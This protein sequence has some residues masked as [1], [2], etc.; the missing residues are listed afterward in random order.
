MNK[1]SFAQ[2]VYVADYTHY[3]EKNSHNPAQYKGVVITTAPSSV[4]SC[5]EFQDENKI[6]FD[7]INL[8]QNP[9]LLKRHDGSLASQCECIF[10]AI[11]NDGGK[12]WMM[13]LE[14]KY[15]IPKN[16]ANN[17]TNALTQLKET[18]RFLKGKG[19]FLPAVGVKPYFVIS[20]PDCESIAPFDETFLDPDELLT[21]K[22]EF[23][24]AQVYHTNTVKVHTAL[25][26][27]TK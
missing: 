9:A 7:T 4:I 23:D 20:M 3:N 21:I 22:E 12:P 18:Y 1:T 24:G 6:V 2:T 15:C 27:K 14:L 16:V 26:L 5:F 19:D 11:R 25:H 13:F 8:E 10:T 17:A